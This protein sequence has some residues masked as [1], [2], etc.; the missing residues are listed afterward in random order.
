MMRNAL[1][2]APGVWC[3]NQF[4]TQ[5]CHR[6]QIA[7][8]LPCPAPSPRALPLRPRTT[9]RH[10]AAALFAYPAR[11][12]SRHAGGACLAGWLHDCS[13]SACLRVCH[14]CL[15]VKFSFHW[16]WQIL[17]KN[18][19]AINARQAAA[20]SDAVRHSH[21]RLQECTFDMLNICPARLETDISKGREREEK[22]IKAT[23]NV[24][25]AAWQRIKLDKVLPGR[26]TST[27]DV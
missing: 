22:E 14:V 3:I 15:H 16:N 21:R 11:H 6:T 12:L 20:Q 8:N 27:D 7:I 19:G 4:A 2:P 10:A 18:F 25:Q 26:P 9:A 5:K 23:F 24:R 13:L 1:P 17:T